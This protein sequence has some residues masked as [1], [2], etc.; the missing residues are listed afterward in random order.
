MI[1]KKLQIIR[2]KQIYMQIHIRR[3]IYFRKAGRRF[4]D[5]IRLDDR[6]LCFRFCTEL[7]LVAI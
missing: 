7:L 6:C 1:G 5:T 4:Y 2:A 3:T